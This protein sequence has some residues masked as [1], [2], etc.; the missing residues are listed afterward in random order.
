VFPVAD[1]GFHNHASWA[2]ATFSVGL[3]D[4]YVPV[5]RLVAVPKTY[6]KPRLIAAEPSEHQFCQQNLWRYFQTQASLSWVGDFVRFND[7]SLNQSLCQKGSLDGSLATIDLSSASDR[8][9]CH[10]VGQ[11]FRHNLGLLDALR[12]S[13]THFLRQ[14][15]DQS[16][17]EVLELNKFSTMGS[18]CTFPVESLVFLGVALAST[19]VKY[20]LA[21]TLGNIRS[22][23]K[24]VAVF[25]DDIIVPSDCRELVQNALELLDFKVNAEKTFS[26]GFFRESCG[27]DAYKGVD[28][29][30]VYLHELWPNTPE[31]TVSMV[32]TAN[33]FYCSFYL[34]TA[35]QIESTLPSSLMTVHVDSGVLGIKSRVG[36]QFRRKRWNA[37]LQRE[38]VRGLALS[39]TVKTIPQEDD[40]SLLQYFTEA[41]E[42]F[43]EWQSGVRASPH[44]KL[45]MGWIDINQCT[46]SAH[47]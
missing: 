40:S 32:D 2:G 4:E 13:R 26:K 22:L 15:L 23:S 46:S 14:R 7:Q 28:V 47:S 35:T 10:V 20:K 37:H 6:E 30:P 36:T 43:C 3:H 41:P 12:A 45:R 16:L 11:F 5:S 39:S 21:P 8:V 31:S 19:L 33:N 34:R 1:Y 9:S 38:E 24:R 17:P 44:L 18:A 25:G 42:P 29:T 27:V